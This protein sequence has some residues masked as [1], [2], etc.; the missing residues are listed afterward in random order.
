MMRH[1]V[2]AMCACL[3]A[4]LGCGADEAAT[5]SSTS[6]QTVHPGPCRGARLSPSSAAAPAALLVPAPAGTTAAAAGPA[7]DGTGARL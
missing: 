4:V 3:V 1:W 2:A 5:L 6:S 7:S